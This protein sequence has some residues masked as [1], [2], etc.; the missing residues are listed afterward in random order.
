MEETK[1]TTAKIVC[2]KCN[3]PFARKDT[4]QRHECQAIQVDLTCEVC[5]KR[6][7]KPSKLIRHRKRHVPKPL[8]KCPCCE[9]EYA[10][11]DHFDRHI[12][13]CSAAVKVLASDESDPE[14]NAALPRSLMSFSD[15]ESDD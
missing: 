7:L 4:L 1:P 6:F 15:Y 14:S 11:R 3:K 13:S 8:F 5:N 9:R 10:R 12:G 2:V